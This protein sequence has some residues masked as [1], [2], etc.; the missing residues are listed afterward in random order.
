MEQLLLLLLS[1]LLS[2]AGIN[3]DKK[4]GEGYVPDLDG[5]CVEKVVIPTQRTTC[6]TPDIDNGQVFFLGTG[7]IVQF[8][9]DTGYVR[10]PDTNTA[11]CQVQGTW[12]KAVPVCL[13]PGCQVI[14]M[15]RNIFL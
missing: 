3:Q 7:R 8:Y 14:I 6:P 11:I 5:S 4:C 13:K 12:S 9:C 15:E 2:V 1:T 10:V